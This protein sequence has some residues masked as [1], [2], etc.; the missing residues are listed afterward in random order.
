MTGA[1]EIDKTKI[2]SLNDVNKYSDN[3][4]QALKYI[5]DTYIFKKR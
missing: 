2:D 3:I 4:N 5:I 1:G